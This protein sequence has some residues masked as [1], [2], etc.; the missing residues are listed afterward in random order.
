MAKKAERSALGVLYTGY[1]EKFN[2]DARFS[3]K[4]KR[5]F[6]VLTHVGLHWFK[7]E[8]GYDLFGEEK[9][10]IMVQDIKEVVPPPESQEETVFHVVTT[11][12]SR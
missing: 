11:D 6:V 12:F 7:R 5:R 2:P 4:H 1:L 10:Y 8:E 3:D 9:G